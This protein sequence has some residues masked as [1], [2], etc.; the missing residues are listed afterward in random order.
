MMD[1]QNIDLFHKIGESERELSL[2]R[3]D[4]KAANA[5]NE[6]LRAE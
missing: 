3:D 6:E 1:I 4:L 2:L 5:R